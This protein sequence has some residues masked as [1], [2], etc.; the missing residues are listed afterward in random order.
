M[1]MPDA[2]VKPRRRWTFIA[3]VVAIIGLLILTASGLCVGL[4]G[5]GMLDTIFT[6]SGSLK[7]STLPGFLSALMTLAMV[8]G[9]PMLLGF[10]LTWAGFRM[11]KKE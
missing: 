3:A 9:I 11:R 10:L 4:V 8:G 1:S 7:A 6:E 5:F 2:P